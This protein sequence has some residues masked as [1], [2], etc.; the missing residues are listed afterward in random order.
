MRI[1]VDLD[2]TIS[3]L[4]E[5]FAL[6]T[7][8]VIT[9]G[10]E[11][12]VITYRP[13]GTEPAIIAELEGHGVAFTRLHVPTKSV[14]APTWKGELAEKLELDLM[15]EDSPE[16]LARMPARTARLWLCD[17]EVFDLDVCVQ[18]MTSALA[19]KQLRHR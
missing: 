17:P 13:A 9:S 2:E 11:I 3:A 7:K 19:G 8:A 6:L 16:V 12:H 1:G 15:I 14:D 5:W 10:H 4:P 18:A